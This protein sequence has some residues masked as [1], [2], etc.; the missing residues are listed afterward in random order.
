MSNG[1]DMRFD[2]KVVLVTGAGGGLGREYAIEFASRGALV[3]VN[4]LGSGKDGQGKTANFADRV[5]EEIRKN[6]GNA[7]ANYDSVEDGEKLIQTA[8][9]NYGKIDIVI[10]NAG[11]LRD[12]SFARIAD[13]DW[14]IIQRV[15]LRGAFKVTRA[16]WP[17]LKKQKYGKVIFT[18]SAAGIYGNFGQ[19]NY[20]AAKLGL[21]GLGNTL[22][23]EGKKDNIGVNT[24]APVAGTRLTEGIMPPFVFDNLKPEYVVPLVMYLSHDSCSET[25]GLFEVGAG[26]VCKLRWQRTQG[27]ILRVEGKKMQAEDVRDNW[28]KV[29]NWDEVDNIATIGESVAKAADAISKISSGENDLFSNHAIQPK[30]AKQHVF[31]PSTYKYSDVEVMLYAA[32]IGASTTHTDDLKFLFELNENFSVIPS[33]GVI[34]PFA[35]LGE[36]MNVNG[37]K[38]NPTKILHG[39]QYLEL[40]RPFDPNGGILISKASICDVLDKNS[41]A[42]IVM[43]VDTFNEKGEKVCFNQTIIFAVGY[44]KF[45]GKRSSDAVKEPMKPP[46]RQPDCSVAEKTTDDQASIYRLCGD[47]NPLH[48]SP[49]FAAMGGFS[50]PILHGLCSFGFATRH[51]MQKYADNN[52]DNIKSIKV[53]FAKPVL[54]GQTLKTNMWKEGSRIYFNTVVV[55]TGKTC[56][57]DSYVDLKTHTSSDDSATNANNLKPK[58]AGLALQSD[59][60]FQEMSKKVN[61]S[62]VK[63]ISAVYQFNITKDGKNAKTWMLDLK[64]GGGSVEE[65][66]NKK[67]DCILTLSD[68]NTIAMF[69]GKLNP[70][71]AFFSGKLKVTGN[72]MLSQKLGILMEKAKL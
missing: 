16:A 37:L 30:L 36:M 43:N 41:G 28:K 50:K 66:A 70:Q 25:G 32:A 42:A 26:H 60:L 7:V 22:A 58:S 20:S 61:N 17:H 5:V 46:S 48:I 71:E 55:E 3:V 63:Q 15:H 59:A 53:R 67:A 57:S 14:D 69:S 1:G 51:V 54:P 11:I 65:G 45:G 34:P 49:Q 47:R 35:S 19:A 23:I 27:A 12:R 21:V 4:D 68:E 62:M 9:E 64:N 31:T 10:N 44:G 29:T 2:G 6:G 8:L 72:I 18:A 13:G 52:P 56:L 33:F 39:E 40:Y 24:I 38:I